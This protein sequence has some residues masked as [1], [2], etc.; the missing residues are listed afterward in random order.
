MQYFGTGKGQR[1][2]VNV[3]DEARR[4]LMAAFLTSAA[5]LETVARRAEVVATTAALSHLR[6]PRSRW[7]LQTD[8]KAATEFF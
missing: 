2:T 3:E 8:F 7:G 5:A 6:W 4:W 1:Q